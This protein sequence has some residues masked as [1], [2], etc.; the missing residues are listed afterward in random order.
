LDILLKKKGH[1]LFR[2][3][4]QTD[5]QRRQKRKKNAALMMKKYNILCPVVRLQYQ[6]KKVNK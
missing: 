1:L 5:R 2:E 3:H 4:R 6:Q